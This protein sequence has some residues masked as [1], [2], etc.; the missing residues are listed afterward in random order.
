MQNHS[1]MNDGFTL[2]L[3][4]LCY[5]LYVTC[6]KLNEIYTISAWI[7]HAIMWLLKP[8]PPA[9]IVPGPSHLALF[10]YLKE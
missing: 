10:L 2:H 3:H 9:C 4:G 7:I 1:K 8:H 5:N 6:N